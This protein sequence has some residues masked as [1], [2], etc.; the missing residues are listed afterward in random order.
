[1]ASALIA[2]QRLEHLPRR[3]E[4]EVGR[5]VP[6]NILGVIV[7]E[8]ETE[9]QRLSLLEGSSGWAFLLGLAFGLM[10]YYRCGMANALGYKDPSDQDESL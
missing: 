5:Y 8:T 4:M 1:M 9:H 10:Y 2:N 7:Y 6:H 3:P